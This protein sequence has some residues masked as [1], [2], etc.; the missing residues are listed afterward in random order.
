MKKEI[1][2][3][4]SDDFFLVN[5]LSSR[6]YKG[7]TIVSNASQDEK[8]KLRNVKLKLKLLAEFFNQKYSNDYGPFQSG[9]VTGNDIA[10]GGAK[11]KPI[12]SGIFKGSHKQYG[13][14]ISFVIDQKK[15]VLHV[16]FY[17][18]RANARQIRKKEREKLESQLEKLAITL[19]SSLASNI[20][21]REKYESLFDLGFSAYTKE[22]KIHSSKWIDS[23]IQNAKTS[24]IVIEVSLDEYGSI[25]YKMIDSYVSQLMFLMRAVDVNDTS[26]IQKAL[27]PEQR[28]KQAERLCMIGYK[29]ELYVFEYEKN[30]LEKNAIKK[31]GYPRHVSLESDSYGYDILSLDEK[32][33]EIFIEVKTTTRTKEDDYSKR[34]YLSANEF[35]TYQNNKDKYKFVRV[36]DVENSPDLRVINFEDFDVDTSSYICKL[37]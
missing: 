4:I 28:A 5:D 6:E 36:Y 1:I 25:D 15:P 22:E 34:F 21:L 20:Q 35:E 7:N 13:A 33:E 19:S 14:Q 16:G 9:V 31:A 17:F 24:Q 12:W 3:L 32:G 27:T 2:S 8:D 11:L 23:I 30:K 37:K 10:M 29:G 18:G 26:L